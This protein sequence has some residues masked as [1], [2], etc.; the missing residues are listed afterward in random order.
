MAAAPN[1]CWEN[2]VALDDDFR[3]DYP[4]RA[5]DMDGFSR[6]FI[7]LSEYVNNTLTPIVKAMA[8]ETGVDPEP[9]RRVHVCVRGKYLETVGER[10][11]ELY[12]AVVDHL[13]P[14]ILSMR[15]KEED[16]PAQG[17][18]NGAKALPAD[19]VNQKRLQ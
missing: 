5:Q 17:S 18:P 10:D 7:R 1:N 12:K 13:T 8:K 15:L 6:N 2:S 19:V 9:L 4:M 16:A 3:R 14:R 11:K